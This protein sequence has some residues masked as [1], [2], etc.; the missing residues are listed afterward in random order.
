M[1]SIN[2]ETPW[3]VLRAQLLW[4][5]WCQRLTH[6]FNDEGFHLGLLLWYAWSHTI[7]AAIEAYKELH[8]HKRNKEKRQEQIE[9]FLQV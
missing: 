6:A 8:R 5:I 9:C 1:F 2:L 7:Y 4:A 3:N